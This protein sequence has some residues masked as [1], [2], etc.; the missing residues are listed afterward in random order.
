MNLPYDMIIKVF[1][2]FSYEQILIMSLNKI[3]YEKIKNNNNIKIYKKYDY[4][5]YKKL[6]NFLQNKLYSIYN[7]IPN[8]EPLKYLIELKL[9][10]NYN[11]PLINNFNELFQN[12]QKLE[13]GFNFNQ[14]IPNNLPNSLQ[15]IIFGHDF[16]QI[17]PDNLP[18]TITCLWFN[19]LYNQPLPKKLPNS[20]KVIKFGKKFDQLLD[21]LLMSK[22]LKEIKLSKNYQ[23]IIPVNLQHLIKY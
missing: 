2:Y 13:F 17:L 4:N 15:E 1:E 16:N 22:N 10:N 14:L 21:N 8:T 20:L 19:G 9:E 7:Y 11:L 3:I 5:N 12:L 18:D 6:P 23:Q